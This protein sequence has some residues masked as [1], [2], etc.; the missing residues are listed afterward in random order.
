MSHQPGHPG[1]ET[2]LL[3]QEAAKFGIPLG[4]MPG[5]G[6]GFSGLMNQEPAVTVKVSDRRPTPSSADRPY[7]VRTTPDIAQVPLSSLLSQ[8]DALPVKKKQELAA[9]MVRAG[10]LP[11]PPAGVTIADWVKKISLS[12][13]RVAYANLLADTAE[14][15]ATGQPTLT[16]VDLLDQQIEYFKGNFKD[17][18]VAGT[19]AEEELFT[20]VDKQK[21]IATDIYSPTEARGLIRNV[22]RAELGREPTDDEFE[23]FRASLNAELEDN[24]SVSVSRQRFVE[25]EPVGPMRTT[26]RGGVDVNEYA[27]NWA[28][29]Q[30][31][32]A[33]W[34]AV[35]RYFPT[36]MNLLGS[37]VPGV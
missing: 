23:D 20:G 19:E 14:R 30:P 27:T 28:Q 18:K 15:N 2:A 4:G 29:S 26:S 8:F 1:G 5:A 11:E 17:G 33:E 16:P 25:G 12:Q 9:D 37:G 32:W 24:P 6:G 3:Q 34:Q 35:G 10:L 13:V 22:L 21:S 31:G 36:A 7:Q